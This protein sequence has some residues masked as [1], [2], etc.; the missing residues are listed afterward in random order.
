MRA[1]TTVAA[2]LACVALAAGCSS[3]AKPQSVSAGDPPGTS[4]AATPSGSAPAP[5]ATTPSASATTKA[6]PTT[7]PKKA[8]TKAAATG[9]SVPAPVHL[10]GPCA[11]AQACGFPGPA[12]TGYRV[13]SLTAHSGDMEVRQD[14]EV[15]NGW[16]LKGSLDV[17][18]NNVTII[19]SRI[20]STNWWAVN[21]RPGYGGLKVLHSTLIGTSTKGLDNGGADYGVSNDSNGSLEVGW[22]DISQFGA[23]VSTGHGT[24][25]DNYSHNQAMFINLGKEW[26]HTDSVISSGDDTGGLLIQH[27]TLINQD[28][29]DKGASASVGLFPDD[30]PVANSTVDDNWMAGGAYALYAG[31]SG[32]HGIVITNNIFSKEISPNGGLYGY[33]AKWSAGGSGNVWSNNRDSSGAIVTPGYGQ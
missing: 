29:V 10:S 23:S 7:S 28:P 32:S 27:N 12:D 24:I 1:I 33:V 8:A 2:V 16:D 19:D 21:L 31:D 22:C 4:A 3:N 13:K 26:V 25:H 6:T 5:S 20:T 15:I 11:N 14:G 9:P 30:G 18:A 17:Y